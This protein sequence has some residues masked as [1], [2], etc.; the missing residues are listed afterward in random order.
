MLSSLINPS[1]NSSINIKWSTFLQHLLLL[2]DQNQY[3]CCCYCKRR[4]S[5]LFC[6]LLIRNIREA[7]NQE[8]LLQF[9]V[10]W[11]LL[12]N[13]Q[14]LA[15]FLE[16]WPPLL[17]QLL[18]LQAKDQ[19]L[20]KTC[21]DCQLSPF[22]PQ[23]FWETLKVSYLEDVSSR[24]PQDTTKYSWETEAARGAKWAKETKGARGARGTK[25]AK[26]TKRARR[27]R[28]AKWA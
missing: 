13:V 10:I 3:C 6:C 19:I 26:K 9:G 2:V 18:L 25:W 14:I 24:S 7:I 28:G 1:I 20:L 21:L 8:M 11:A 27:A 5:Y 12:D 23:N 22:K 16:W 17:L 4:T 15:T